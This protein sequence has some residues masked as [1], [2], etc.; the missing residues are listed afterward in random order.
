METKISTAT[1]EDLL[2]KFMQTPVERLSY[3]RAER[4]YAT[5]LSFQL[6]NEEDFDEEFYQILEDVLNA[7]QRYLLR[8][9]RS[10]PNLRRRLVEDPSSVELI[11]SEMNFSEVLEAEKRGKKLK[12]PELREQ[13]YNMITRTLEELCMKTTSVEN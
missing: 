7:L 2:R 11:L 1:I 9:E 10:L 3:Q 12:S 8:K 4:L 6:D 5:L 13:F